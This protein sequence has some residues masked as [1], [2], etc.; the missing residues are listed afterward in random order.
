MNHFKIETA[1]K[2]ATDNTGAVRVT[3][4]TDGV[5]LLMQGFDFWGLCCFKIYKSFNSR[6]QQIFT[7]TYPF[8][9]K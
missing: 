9:D 3:H 6:M 7:I 1:I 4:A 2:E 5:N 8:T